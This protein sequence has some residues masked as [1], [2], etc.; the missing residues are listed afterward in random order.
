[1]CPFRGSISSLPLRNSNSICS[2]CCSISSFPLCNCNSILYVWTFCRS[3]SS[4]G[5]R[6]SLQGSGMNIES[7]KHIQ[8]TLPDNQVRVFKIWIFRSIFRIVA[9][10]S[11][12]ALQHGKFRFIFRI[13]ARQ[14]GQALQHGTLRYIF[15]IVA[16]QSVRAGSS[17]W[18]HS[19]K[20]L[21]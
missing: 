12:Q 17:T 19:A 4:C 3:N 2:F 16:R 15:R 9:R 10:Q 5:G 21:E 1:M 13:V 14:S 11:G 8:V 20:Y 18:K 6:R 7:E